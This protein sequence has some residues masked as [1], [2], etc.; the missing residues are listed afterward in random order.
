MKTIEITL[1]KFEEL[2]E[3]TQQIAIDGVR[4]YEYYLD[5]EWYD[6]VFEGVKEAG[7][8]LGI[9]V[10]KIYFSGFSSQGDGAC[11][12]GKYRYQKE[13]LKNIT[14]N[15]PDNK[16]LQDIAFHLQREQKA[17][18]YGIMADVKHQGN[19]YHENSTDIR[20]FHNYNSK[21]VTDED[22]IIDILR[23]FMRWIYKALELEY[24]Y[25]MSDEAVIES[26]KANGYDFNI[27]GERD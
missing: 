21:N 27:E 5:Y 10:D 9:E 15:W 7:G 22:E 13:A 11:F 18:F 16:T 6:G 19:Y 4:Y 26:I 17:N 1:Y 2:S 14:A 20:V 25:L 3:E 24:E 8:Y 23:D 12:E